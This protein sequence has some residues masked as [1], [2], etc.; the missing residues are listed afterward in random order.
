MKIKKFGEK[1]F[2]SLDKYA[3][4]HM[5]DKQP[6]YEI[7]EINSVEDKPGDF[8]EYEYNST[9]V[10]YYSSDSDRFVRFKGGSNKYG[11]FFECEISKYILYSSDSLEDCKEMVKIISNENKY[12]L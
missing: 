7:L 6:N 8:P 5:P 4:W 11:I 1:R 12:N 10:Y 3:I 9:I 2:K